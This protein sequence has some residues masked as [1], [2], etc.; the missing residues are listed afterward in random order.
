M[1]CRGHATG[2]EGMSVARTP[3]WITALGVVAVVA[4]I[5]LYQTPAGQAGPSSAPE[6]AVERIKRQDDPLRRQQD[7]L[8]RA[9]LGVQAE[10]AWA[11]SSEE[12][13][14]LGVEFA[15]AQPKL[16]DLLK[17]SMLLFR[18]LK[19][20]DAP[21]RDVTVVFRTD[22]LKDVYGHRLPG[23]VIGRLRLAGETFRRINWYGFNPRNFELLADEWWVHPE[24][25]AAEQPQGAP[26]GGQGPAGQGGGSSGGAGA[27]GGG[28]A[29]IGVGG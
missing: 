13:W 11:E 17:K 19:H 15:R 16:D 26:G 22:Q 29:G 20:V 6:R 14:S 3:R 27:G 21:L 18:E 12:G 7:A 25:L 24:V 5:A 9:V 2:E 4:G 28:S 23:V 1:T 8:R 10:L